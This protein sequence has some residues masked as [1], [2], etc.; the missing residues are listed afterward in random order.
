MHAQC[1]AA[2][3]RAMNDKHKEAKKQLEQLQSKVD[4]LETENKRMKR[5]LENG[6][7]EHRKQVRIN[8]ILETHW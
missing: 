5:E 7:M 2:Q 4:E 8:L 6:K 1:Q 3:L